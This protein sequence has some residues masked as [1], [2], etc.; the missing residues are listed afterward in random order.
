L[1]AGRKTTGCEKNLSS[2]QQHQI[3]GTQANRNDAL[4]MRKLWVSTLRGIKNVHARFNQRNDNRLKPAENI[5]RPGN[6]TG[7]EGNSNVPGKHARIVEQWRVSV[8]G[9]AK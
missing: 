5:N 4:Q 3:N 2:L 1:H 6:C 7:F 9:K 8:H